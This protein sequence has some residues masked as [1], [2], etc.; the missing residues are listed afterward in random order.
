MI[1]DGVNVEVHHLLI[2]NFD[3]ERLCCERQTASQHRIHVDASET[4]PKISNLV[5]TALN[6][7]AYFNYSFICG[8]GSV[9]FLFKDSHESALLE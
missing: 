8:F 6:S 1:R 4:T 2:E 5:E 7:G 9:F 3:G